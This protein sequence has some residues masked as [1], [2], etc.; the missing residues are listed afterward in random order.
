MGGGG[1]RGGG[2]E[3]WVSR[4]FDAEAAHSVTGQKQAILAILN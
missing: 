1:V 3:V 2:G 4:G